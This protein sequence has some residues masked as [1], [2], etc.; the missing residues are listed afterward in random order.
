M[1]ICIDN[2]E[3]AKNAIKGGASRLEVCSALSEGGLTPTPGFLSL[4]RK[5][6]PIKIYAMI[7][8]RAGNFVYTREEMDAMLIDIEALKN[9]KTDGF[10]FGAL[11]EEGE[12]HVDFCK[13]I[14][15]AARP[16]PVTYHR[17]FDQVNE[18][19]K[20]LETLCEVGFERVLTSGQRLSALEGISLIKKLIELAQAR[21]IIMPG[22]GITKDNLKAIKEKS[23]A[24]EFHASAKRA[25][26]FLKRSTDVK[27]GSGTD[28]CV[29][30]TDEELVRELV[31]ILKE[32]R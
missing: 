30:V 22:A 15:T 4:I 20:S 16:F 9:L 21:I 5:I 27:I 1:E 24:K 29:M 25:K 6:S 26:K 2:V 32:N 7:R 28:F 10:V 17:A 14:I 23:G 18:P 19:L 12:I 31:N 8:V 11:T 13:E 3:S